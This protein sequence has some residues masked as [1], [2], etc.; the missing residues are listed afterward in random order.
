M[1]LFD[2]GTKIIGLLVD[3]VKWREVQRDKRY[4]LVVQPAF[5]TMQT[6]H[7]DL[8]NMLRTTRETLVETQSFSVAFD[9]FD[10]NRHVHQGLR[11]ELRR[12]CEFLLADEKLKDCHA[13]LRSVD[14]YFGAGPFRE[15]R[16]S[17]RTELR[18]VRH[19]TLREP[20]LPAVIVELDME[21]KQLKEAWLKI[22]D[23]HAAALAASI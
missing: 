14:H 23:S 8:V 9:E 21:I 17:E 11:H 20:N 2:A 22:A 3:L 5:A 6:V 15:L 10:R 19:A 18:L 13:F 16:V 1:T 12:R 7:Q 4:K